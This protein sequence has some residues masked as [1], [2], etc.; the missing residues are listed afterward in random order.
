MT[1]ADRVFPAVDATTR[2]PGPCLV[3]DWSLPRA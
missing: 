2:N 1:V 3:P